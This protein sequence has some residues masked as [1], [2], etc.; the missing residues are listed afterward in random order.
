MLGGAEEAKRTAFVYSDEFAR[1]SYG[2][3]HPLKMSRLGLTRDLIAACG[4]L[5]LRNVC[6]VEAPPASD[7]DL[8]IYH[9]S[10]YLAALKRANEGVLP[11]GAYR[12]G[13]GPGDNPVFAGLLDW[14]R[15][16]AGAS[17][18][19]ASLVLNGD[20]DI[21]F[22]ISGG[23]HH[24]TASRASG[25]CYINDAAI[26]IRWLLNKGT[27]IAYI[28]ID[29]HHG[30]GVQEAFYDSEDV[31]TI[32]IHQTGRSLFPGTGFEDETGRG[33]GIGCSVNVPMPTGADDELFLFAFEEIVPPL[34]VAFKPD[35]V[36]S[37]LGVDT[38][39]SDPLAGLN[40]TTAGFCHAVKRIKEISPRWA[41]LGGGGYNVANVAR[42]WTL[43]W[44]I[45]NGVEVPD[46]IPDHFLA[47]HSREGFS[48][49]RIRD[50]AYTETGPSKERLRR[51]VAEVVARVKKSLPKG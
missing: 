32:S 47:A 40:Y 10:A 25:F 14:S 28:D 8:L 45:M 5:S 29:A 23:L 4:L 37:Q 31:L 35:I 27:R 15:L 1:F 49:G 6:Y 19:A 39:R 50:E 48:T 36:V 22:S 17:L 16:V 18:Q 46:S 41:A 21:A 2:P 9:D 34:I 38:F 7:E 51:E 44:A 26:A 43:A 30:D 24:A 42:A 11:P 3:T 33:K 12:Y 13:L 20:A